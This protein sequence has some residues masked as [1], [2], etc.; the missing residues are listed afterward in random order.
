M[1]KKLLKLLL[2]L[3]LVVLLGVI[4]LKE[5]K[6]EENQEVKNYTSQETYLFATHSPVYVKP[7]VLGIKT[8]K[9][10]ETGKLEGVSGKELN[11]KEIIKE[12]ALGTGV[13]WQDLWILAKY[14]SS[15]NPNAINSKGEYSVGIFQINLRVHD[16]TVD[17]AK[18]VRFATKWTIDNLIRNGYLNGNRTY[19]IG[20]HQG[21]WKLQI[22]QDRARK[23]VAEANQL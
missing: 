19:S 5:D 11:I 6:K 17:Q 1:S 8:E 14:E 12:E 2:L 22:V 20:R 3:S 15:W 23:I 4:T 18:D 21:S 13:K 10:A 7:E 9:V 16:V